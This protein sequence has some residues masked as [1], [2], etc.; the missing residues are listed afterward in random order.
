MRVGV[1]AFLFLCVCVLHWQ[2]FRKVPTKCTVFKMCFTACLCLCLFWCS[3]L[4]MCSFLLQSLFDSAL[5][6]KRTQLSTS[7][8]LIST[9]T[10]CRKLSFHAAFIFVPRSCFPRL[11]DLLFMMLHLSIH[12]RVS[13]WSSFVLSHTRRVFEKMLAICRFRIEFLPCEKR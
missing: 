10:C 7:L 6:E 3:Y 1:R 5:V 12:I 11:S 8:V 9:Y 13:A 4:F 2:S